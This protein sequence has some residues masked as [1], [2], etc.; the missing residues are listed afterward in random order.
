MKLLYSILLI[1]YLIIG[2][3]SWIG[4]NPYDINSYDI[5]SPNIVSWKLTLIVSTVFIIL[6]SI[7]LYTLQK[8]DKK[9]RKD[10]N[11]MS[12][13]WKEKICC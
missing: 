2:I 6:I 11:K 3:V 5:G 13:M 4:S 7:T 10:E 12:N 9:E 1:M 8:K